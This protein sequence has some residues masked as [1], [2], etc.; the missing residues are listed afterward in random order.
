MALQTGTGMTICTNEDADTFKKVFELMEVE[1]IKY[2]LGDGDKGIL[3]KF[4]PIQ[5]RIASWG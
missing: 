4:G 5:R 3:K 2:F 1:Y